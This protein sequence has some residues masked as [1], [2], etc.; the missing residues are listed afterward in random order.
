[1]D[2]ARVDIVLS[3]IAYQC[4]RKYTAT[5]APAYAVLEEA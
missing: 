4:L 2:R 5:S 1:M 3:D